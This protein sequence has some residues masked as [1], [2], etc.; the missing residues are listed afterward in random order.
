GNN[1]FI[2]TNG[3][4]SDLGVTKNWALGTS[5]FSYPVGTMNNYTPVSLTLTVTN[6]GSITVAPVNSRHP[7]YGF[8]STEQILNYYWIVRRDNAITYTTVGSHS[9]TYST[10]L[11]GGGGGARVAGFLDLSNPTGWVTS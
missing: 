5:T 8:L 1:R 4:S 10:G 3:V 6:P 2:R 7:S 11:M 9:Y